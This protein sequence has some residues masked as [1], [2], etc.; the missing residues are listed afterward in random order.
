MDDYQYLAFFEDDF[1]YYVETSKNFIIHGFPSVDLKTPTNGY[2]PLWFL[3]ITLIQ[4][5]SKNPYFITL[6]VTIISF[7]SLCFSY[8]YLNKLFYHFSKNNSISNYLS[9][10]ATS[11]FLI[12][13]AQGMEIILLFPLLSLLFYYLFVRQTSPFLYGLLF[14]ILFLSRLDIVFLLIPI[15]IFF[16]FKRRDIVNHIWF[17]LPFTISFLYVGS[18]IVL[19]DTLL[20]VSGMAKQIKTSYTP[21]FTAFESI[22]FMQR[23]RIIYGLIPFIFFVSNFILIKTSSR[24]EYRIILL[25][26]N[27][28][29]ILFSIYNMIFSGWYYWSWYYYIFFPS[30]VIFLLLII[31]TKL[32]N[33]SLS[34]LLPIASILI[35]LFYFHVSR[36]NDPMK[37]LLYEN[38]MELVEYEK[39]H[40]GVYAMGD[41]AG[42]ISYLIESPLVHLEGLVMDKQYIKDLKSTP[43]LSDLLE[44]YNVDYYIANN[45]KKLDN[46]YRIEEPFKIH[47]YVYTSKDTLYQI[48]VVME[49]RLN[50]KFQVFDLR[51]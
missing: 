23:D 22:F 40:P 28:F 46:G 15:Y 17:Y 36:K 18:N 20:P 41:K 6:V 32:F 39:Q 44:K 13:F 31:N 24:K 49:D 43:K 37:T 21:V 10:V 7:I 16:L 34:K 27:I 5:V 3:I 48:P 14:N 2:H 9:I 11:L 38:A 35:I 19:F 42:L 33:K 51:K 50:W 47:K 12:Y 29:P 30:I 25:L 45:A 4:L 1:F 8:F 26:I